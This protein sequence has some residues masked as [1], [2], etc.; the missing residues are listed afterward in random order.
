MCLL[1]LLPLNEHA[2]N[3]SASQNFMACVNFSSDLYIRT[4]PAVVLSNKGT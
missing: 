4:K 2:S 1:A 3:N